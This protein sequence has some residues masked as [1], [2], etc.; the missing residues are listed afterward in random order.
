MG[1][2]WTQLKHKR[3]Q[4]HW[5]EF[6]WFIENLAQTVQ[7]LQQHKAGRG[8]VPEK[9]NTQADNPNSVVPAV[10]SSSLLCCWHLQ[11]NLWRQDGCMHLQE[12]GCWL[13]TVVVVLW[14]KTLMPCD[15]PGLPHSLVS[16][17]FYGQREMKC[18]AW[19]QYMQRFPLLWHSL[20]PRVSL[21]QPNNMGSGSAELVE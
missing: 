17:V 1:G 15:S 19:L 2:I 14:R 6:K 9:P 10:R 21:V 11:Q 16:P 4:N 5:T 3:I 7:K 8:S 13:G 12:E 20:S 18:P